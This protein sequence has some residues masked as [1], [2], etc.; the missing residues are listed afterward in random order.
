MND[1]IQLIGKTVILDEVQ[2]EYFEKII[3]WRNNN[4]NNKFL[5]QPYRLTLDLQKK[6]YESYLKDD[7]QGL[8]ILIDKQNNRPFGTM[9]WTDFDKN[10][11]ICITGRL[12]VGDT[13]YRGSSYFRE[14][15]KLFNNYLYHNYN[16]KIMYAHVIK[17]NIASIKWHEKWGYNINKE[18][19]FSKEQ[20][21]NGMEQIEF[22]RSFDDYY[23]IS[24]LR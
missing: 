9:G 15:T 24:K 17:E 18:F 21:V 1:K 22:F 14:A 23:K 6:W 4:E 11:Q 12:L 7:T 3:E 8:L 5:N 20:V 13:A 16:I 19:K 2:P 10:Q